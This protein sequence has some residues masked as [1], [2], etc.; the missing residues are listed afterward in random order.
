MEI[1]HLKP[2]IVKHLIEFV[3]KDDVDETA[4]TWELFEAAKMYD[5]AGLQRLCLTVIRK[6]LDV[7]NCCQMLEAT[8]L[9]DLPDLFDLVVSFLR[10]FKAEVMQTDDWPR[11]AANAKL[12][13]TIEQWIRKDC[14]HEISL[15]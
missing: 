8:T 9:H 2:D 14:A 11:V 10:T 5:L 12:M 3:Y 7:S 4:V 15:L 13:A 6:R 1:N